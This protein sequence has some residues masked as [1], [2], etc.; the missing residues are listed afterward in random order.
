MSPRWLPRSLRGRFVLLMVAGVL[1]A[2]L[3]SQL[4][5]RGQAQALHLELV[6]RVARSLAASV[7]STV[8][9]VG[10]LPYEYRHLVLDQ[11][12]NMGGQRFFVSVNSRRLAVNDLPGG[13]DKALV[14]R[15]F[16]RTLQRELGDVETH[17]EFSRPEDL[18]VLNRELQLNELPPRWA[19]FVL[20]LDD[21]SAAS[22]PL[23]VVQ[24]RLADDEWL[25]VA[26]QVP[27]P[28]FLGERSLLAPERALALFATLAAVLAA[29][30][31]G[32][33]WL[34][35]PL[36]AVAR[37][38]RDLGRDLWHP[39][40]PED[41]ATE[42]AA[43]AHAF[44]R[45]QERLQGYLDDRARLFS[46]ISHDLKTPITRL[47]LRAE[48]LPDE[49]LRDKFVAD[50][51]ELNL[52]V[53]GALQSVKDTDIHENPE[54]V[55]VAAVLAHLGEDLDLRGRAF[56]LSGQAQPLRARPLALRRCLANLI[57][58]AA[59]YGE[60][61]EV[62]LEDT[63]ERL[64]VRLYDYGAG[65]P[66]AAIEQVFQPYVRLERSRNRNTGGS[67]LGL[68]IARHIARAHGGE[69][70]LHNHPQRGLEARLQLPRT[71]AA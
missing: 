40:L 66:E 33:R 28:G 20:W 45:M 64:T 4:V 3:G 49:R 67:G 19:D 71:G 24:V 48:L 41:G 37:A 18:R 5:W 62:E 31:V 9:Y 61:V 16:L 17:V 55:D 52:M 13:D 21:A 14:V 54:P 36:S 38:A 42:I 43:T 56:T 58:N 30:L 68:G 34:T 23:L 1:L 27:V 47:R 44:N 7:S 2:Q 26:S 51:D 60:R 39:P 32:V 69:L 6:E 50:L 8:R 10:A 63:P 57:D 46:A 35:Q 11:L 15:A 22:L 59:F 25:Y 29:S 12:R 70:T 53:Q 65:I